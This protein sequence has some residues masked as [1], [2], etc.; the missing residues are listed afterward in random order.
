MSLQTAG[1]MLYDEKLST[2]TSAK[3]ILDPILVG[4][5]VSR[6]FQRFSRSR[7][8]GPTQHRRSRSAHPTLLGSMAYRNHKPRA[9]SS[10]NSAEPSLPDRLASALKSLRPHLN[11]NQHGNRQ[12]SM[13]VDADD[14]VYFANHERMTGSD[15]HGKHGHKCNSKCQH[16]D[17]VDDG[18]DLDGNYSSNESKRKARQKS[19]PPAE[20]K[21]LDDLRQLY[22]NAP[23]SSQD[24]DDIENNIF[25]PPKRES[26]STFNSIDLKPPVPSSSPPGSLSPRSPLV[27]TSMTSSLSSASSS[28]S[29][30]DSG[31]RSHK[32]LQNDLDNNN[33]PDVSLIY[34][35]DGSLSST[36]VEKYR[37]SHKEDKGITVVKVDTVENSNLVDSDRKMEKIKNGSVGQSKGQKM[38]HNDELK[39]PNGDTKTSYTQQVFNDL[40]HSNLQYGQQKMAALS[41]TNSADKAKTEVV[42]DHKPKSGY[43]LKSLNGLNHQALASHSPA[44]SSVPVAHV[45]PTVATQ[46]ASDAV[47]NKLKVSTVPSPQ[48]LYSVPNHQTSSTVLNHQTSSTVQNSQPSSTA[49][50]TSTQSDIALFRPTRFTVPFTY[51]TSDMKSLIEQTVPALSQG[52]SHEL[53]MM[54]LTRFRH[55]ME[56][57]SVEIQRNIGPFVKCAVRDINLSLMSLLPEKTAYICMD[58]AVQTLA[59]FSN[60]ATFTKSLEA[61]ASLKMNVGKMYRWMKLSGLTD[62]V[63]D[64]TA[65]Y[66]TAVFERLLLLYIQ[67]VEKTRSNKQFSDVLRQHSSLFDAFT[68]ND[69]TTGI[70]IPTMRL[71]QKLLDI[72]AADNH[73]KQ[74]KWHKRWRENHKIGVRFDEDGLNCLFFYIRCNEEGQNCNCVGKKPIFAHFVE[75]I[76]NIVE[77]RNSARINR[78]DVMEAA[79]ILKLIDKL[80][81]RSSSD[82]IDSPDCLEWQWLEQS[83]LW[84]VD[85]AER[86]KI[87]GQCDLSRT[88]S[89]GLSCLSRTILNNNISA[90]NLIVHKTNAHLDTPISPSNLKGPHKNCKLFDDFLGWT[91]LFWAVVKQDTE[92]VKKL[93]AQNVHVNAGWMR[94][95]TPLQLAAASGSPEIIHLLL[96]HRADPQFTLVDYEHK[97]QQNVAGAPAALAIAAASGNS[98]AFNLILTELRKPS[99]SKD[100]LPASIDEH[101]DGSGNVSECTQTVN[102]AETGKLTQLVLKEALYYAVECGN[103]DIAFDLSALGVKWTINLWTKCLEWSVQQKSNQGIKLV[104]DSFVLRQLRQAPLQALEMFNRKLFDIIDL[105]FID[106]FTENAVFNSLL[107]LTSSIFKNFY[108]EDDHAENSVSESSNSKPFGVMIDPKYCDNEK[109]SDVKFICE[110]RKIYA[111]RIALVNASQQFETILQNSV[112]SV[113]VNDISYNTFKALIEFVYGKRAECLKHIS[114]EPINDQLKTIQSAERFGLSELAELIAKEISDNI[115]VSNCLSIY[116]HAIKTDNNKLLKR[117][118]PFILCHLEELLGRNSPQH[119]DFLQIN[120]CFDLTQRLAIYSNRTVR[121]IFHNFESEEL[122]IHKL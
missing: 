4:G 19:A 119:L 111:H 7:A 18:V 114:A 10:T 67:T 79:R 46:H 65:V 14:V 82:F 95:E 98:Q 112:D 40:R 27:T 85:Q 23:H 30:A 12:K 109:F 42:L 102:Y 76:L 99:F 48:A 70:C 31:Y 13:V 72:D 2:V 35:N 113:K 49:S 24:D 8:D 63:V 29:A 115:E 117:V 52:F 62:V 116:Q 91:P 93:L 25:K 39:R 9:S 20:L 26:S 106:Q 75:T 11:S 89:H 77:H 90:A 37:G 33:K 41:S 94:R 87:F 104:L 54:L 36:E 83:R 86:R 44:M 103:L 60:S 121:Q 6:E 88:N 108:K 28:R 61:R 80:P 59:F 66:L 110:N 34:I 100:N 56:V 96:K 55:S 16:L 47:P 71:L 107:Q 64:V 92:M 53:F 57:F 74:S 84:E 58:Y 51:T 45:S 43:H 17:N 78:A 73:V 21:T 5:S 22:K 97:D 15:I 118:E 69:L 120:K 1:D 101:G 3:R 38:S 105:D 81:P 122:S 68:I 50:Y 32:R